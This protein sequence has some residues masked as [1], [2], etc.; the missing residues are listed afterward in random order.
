MWLKPFVFWIN[1]S[2][3]ENAEYEEEGKLP[4][5]PLDDGLS[6]FLNAC[7]ELLTTFSNGKSMASCLNILTRTSIS[8]FNLLCADISRQQIKELQ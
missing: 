7:G 4:S 1:L 8:Q 5:P 2:F 3:V 6:L